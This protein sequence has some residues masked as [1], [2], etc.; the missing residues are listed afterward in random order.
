MKGTLLRRAAAMLVSAALGAGLCGAPAHAASDDYVHYYT[1]ASASENL[2]EIAQRFL[3]SPARSTEIFNLNTGRRQ[4]DGG[5]LAD[6]NRL[7]AGWYL[8]LPW[9]AVGSG[10][11]YGILPTGKPASTPAET[12]PAKPRVD[13][14]SVAQTKIKPK[15]S[16]TPGT[17]TAAPATGKPSRWGMLKLAAE[18]AWKH[19]RGSGQLVAIVDSGVDGRAP[20]LYGRVTTGA[21]LVTVGPGDID[22]LGTGTAMAGLVAAKPLSGLP[23]G[24]MAPDSSVMPVRVVT[25]GKTVSRT[26]HAAAIE[27]AVGAGASVIALGPYVDLDDGAVVRAVRNAI[28]RNVVVVAPAP[29][30]GQA[31]GFAGLPDAVI[32]VGGV[33]ENGMP[34]AVY[35]PRTVDVVAPG[36]N[37]TSIGN[38]GAGQ[39]ADSGTRYAVALTAGTAALVR[40]A[41]PELTAPQVA[42]RVTVTSDRMKGAQPGDSYGNGMVDPVAAIT[43]ELP[44]E[45]TSA[46]GLGGRPEPGNRLAWL[47][48]VLIVLVG[49]L[50]ITLLVFRIRHAF[51]A[52]TASPDQL[53]LDW[54]ADP[55][56]KL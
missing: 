47:S 4:P 44:E 30:A 25:D 24:G 43:R 41:H 37:I 54:P 51:R 8:V 18:Q 42:H 48:L 52:G 5:R 39:R 56:P 55:A 35:A 9:D 28:E 11:A 27:T 40:S 45:A 2:M 17:C 1:V 50:L 46:S 29:V 6:Q 14:Q 21:D 16:A 15:G 19:S 13:L 20:Q 22:C 32:V 12:P 34:A 49:G 10:V 31:P 3:G 38:N 33:A 23:F 7:Q 26:N 36:V 53:D